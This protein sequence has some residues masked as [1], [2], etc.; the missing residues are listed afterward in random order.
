MWQK[1]FDVRAGE[2]HS[3]RLQMD[4]SALDPSRKVAHSPILLK[5]LVAFRPPK[6]FRDIQVVL[7]TLVKVELLR[8]G[9]NQSGVS[10]FANPKA[11]RI[12]IQY[13]PKDCD[14]L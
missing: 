4:A 7:Y 3:K 6:F 5:S 10:A 8:T 11:C 12:L 13:W 14:G 1:P 9:A 2:C